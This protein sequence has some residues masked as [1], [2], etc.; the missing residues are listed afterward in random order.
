VE[1]QEEEEVEEEEEEEI[2]ILNHTWSTCLSFQ[3]S[4]AEAER[5]LSLRPVWEI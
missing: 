4:G 5:M 1:E 3:H 2:D